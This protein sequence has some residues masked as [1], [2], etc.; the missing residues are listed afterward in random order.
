MDTQSIRTLL[1]QGDT[2]KALET[3]IALLERDIRYR[4]TFARVLRVAE[5]NY[6]AVRQQELKGILSFQEAQREYSRIADVVL[7]VLDDVEAGRVPQQVNG[8]AARRRTLWLAGLG[9][10][11]I[12]ALAIWVFRNPADQA[13]PKYEVNGLRVLVLP[14]D[15]L[16]Q[17]AAQPEILIRDEINNLAK[18]NNINNSF[19]VEARVYKRRE[20]SALSH[21]EAAELAGSCSGVDLVVWG[22]YLAFDADSIRVKVG[23]QFL[24]DDKSGGNS[25]FM[26]FRDVT[27]ISVDRNLKDAVFSIC[28]MLAIRRGQSDLARRWLA[29]VADEDKD[30]EDR[31]MMEWLEKRN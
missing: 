2:G 14:F 3:L 30:A 7:T 12:A 31:K 4:D 13:C 28:S 5:N 24:R 20:S 27:A 23:F 19:P 9:L 22:Q 15:Q 17:L 8:T 11:L 6:N 25:A 18:K 10:V 16:G 26:T 29:K 21:A 1:S